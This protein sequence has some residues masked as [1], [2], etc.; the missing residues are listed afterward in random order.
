MIYGKHFSAKWWW[1]AVLFLASGC[2]LH[3]GTSEIDASKLPE[4]ST[5]SDRLKALEEETKEPKERAPGEITITFRFRP[6]FILHL[7]GRQRVASFEAL[8]QDAQSLKETTKELWEGKRY[9]KAVRGI[10]EQAIIDGY[11]SDNNP[12]VVII[13]EQEPEPIQTE[14]IAADIGDIEETVI[15][16]MNRIIQLHGISTEAIEEE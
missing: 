6:Q 2:T 8:N 7:D 10:T 11:I 13:A 9:K 5:V 14:S 12:D 1:L 3:G 16:E 4:T 15:E